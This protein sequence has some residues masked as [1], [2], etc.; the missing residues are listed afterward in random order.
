MVTPS[1]S[2]TTYEYN[3]ANQRIK[4]TALDGSYWTY[5]YDSLGQVTSAVKRHADT[6]PRPGHNFSYEFDD[7]GNRTETTLNNLRSI[8]SPNLTNQYLSRSTPPAIPVLGTA[9]SAA[10]VKVNGETA[11][12]RAG[13][14]FYHEL[15]LDGSGASQYLQFPVSATTEQGGP[16]ATSELVRSETRETFVPAS[17]ENFLHDAD[18]NLTQDGRWTYTW[19][20]ENRLI[21][22]ETRP[23]IVTAAPGLPRQRL[24][25]TYDAQGHRIG[26]KLETNTSGWTVTYEKRFVYDGWNL[27]A[28][29]DW[30]SSAS[31]FSLNSSFA[32]GLD[33]SSSTHNAGGIGGL[34]W[35]ATGSASYSS[36]YDGNGNIIAWVDLNTGAKVAENDYDAFGNVIKV[37]GT[38]PVHFGFS[39]KYEDSETGLLYYGFRYYAPSTGR[40]LNRDPIGERGGLNAYG[41]V[42]GDAINQWDYL[43]LESYYIPWPNLT[44]RLPPYQDDAGNNYTPPSG[45]TQAGMLNFNLD[46]NSER[47]LFTVNIVA[48]TNESTIKIW[49]DAVRGR[50]SNRFK[51][52]CTCLSAPIPI[53]VELRVNEDFG[54]QPF[55]HVA[56]INSRGGDAFNWGIAGDAGDIGDTAA[57][58][59]GHHLGAPDRYQLP[60]TSNISV[61]FPYVSPGGS[62]F[63]PAPGTK[64]Q[65][66]M[67]NSSELP[68]QID[69]QS[70]WKV[71][72]H[73]LQK[74]GKL[75]DSYACILTPMSKPCPK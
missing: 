2:S 43:G 27:V 40:W 45:A 71:I 24:T 23:E 67:N 53:Q 9:A 20:A 61:S 64:G 38:N 11:A 39:T 50:W 73:E 41:M 51:I 58:E 5:G 63:Y 55:A 42:N 33:L 54:A 75:S 28:E 36:A 69:Y 32:W 1:I 44:M 66:I 21:G 35:V 62:T 26:K 12:N 6:T 25:F 72:M 60:N 13:A 7:I 48:R 17:P 52:C 57:H 70:M 18:G 46:L 37:A 56:V 15:A 47:A 59:V 4:A 29:L 10:T 30:N 31:T 14:W 74:S 3:D 16:P 8:Y 34:L 49:K 65:G 19:D 22:M 68:H